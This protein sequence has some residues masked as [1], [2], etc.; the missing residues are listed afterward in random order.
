MEQNE[1][2]RE[3]EDLEQEARFKIISMDIDDDDESEKKKILEEARE[4][5]T[6][7]YREFREWLN[8]NI[9]S[10]EVNERLE[11]LKAETGNLI[12]RT[13]ERMQAFGEDER[14]VNGRQKA[15]AFSRRC[16]DTVNDGFHD[17][18]NNEHVANIVDTIADTVENVR[19]DERVQNGVRRFKKGTL[20]IA[21]SAFNGL[22]R[23]L[24]TDD[25][26]NSDQKG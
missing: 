11:R 25:D 8:D 20:K 17:V 10:D 6:R 18:M 22:K 13:K 3:V 19:S 12:A 5:I 14:V 23:V 2:D 24:D 9:S 1:R 16:T 7:L 4:E 15:K 26:Q 21:E